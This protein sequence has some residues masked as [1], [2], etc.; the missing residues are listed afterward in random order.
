MQRQID[1]SWVLV[2]SGGG[3]GAVFEVAKAVARMGPR[4]IVSG[5][6]P[7]PNGDEPYLE[8]DDEAFEAYRREQMVQARAK[9]PSLTPVKF[10]E[11]FEVCVRAREL[12]KNL[13]EV[14]Q[15]GIRCNMKSATFVLP[16][17]SRRS[18]RACAPRMGASTAWCTAQ[19]SSTRKACSTRCQAK[20]P[21]HSKSKPLGS[22]I[23][24]KARAT[25]T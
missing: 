11:Q 4:V 19:C 18:S 12:W 16:N 1:P 21:P 8:L 14:F 6:T 10:D 22:F 9:E 17:R 2:F 7:V 13:A 5:R 25:M 24:S 15:L 3:R 20:S 23:C